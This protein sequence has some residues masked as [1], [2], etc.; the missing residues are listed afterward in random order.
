MKRG[1][2]WVALL[3]S[4]GINIGVLATIGVSRARAKAG[5]E[6]PRDRGGSPPVERLATH[7]DLDGEARD[8]FLD[9]QQT[10]FRSMQ[11]HQG[12][13]QELRTEIRREIM[14]DLPDPLNVDRLLG[15]VGAI[16]MDLDRAMVESV[17]ATRKILT[18]EQQKRYFE[19]LERWQGASRRFAGR[20]GP[21][22]R[23]GRRPPPP[24]RP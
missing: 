6:R 22:G 23:P 4:V 21:P 8:Q 17:S 9:I 14:S 5:L 11:Q 2:V 10:L 19:V 7:L 13:L 16:H 24:D 15:E 3:L 18:P 1:W 20:G 12:S